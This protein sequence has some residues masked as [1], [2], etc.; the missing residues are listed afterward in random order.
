[1]KPRRSVLVQLAQIVLSFELL[2]ILLAGLT[3][4]GLDALQG[5]S[6]PSWVALV[7]TLGLTIAGIVAIGL[8]RRF[9]VLGLGL[10]WIIQI[11]LV[12][13]GFIVPAIWFV[14]ALFGGLWIYVIRAGSRIDSDAS[15]GTLRST[16]LEN[17]ERE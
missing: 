14:A 1:M 3:I 13:M 15:Q 11:S 16:T 17:G 5:L 7:A 9:P 2:I 10:G 12:V 8:L 6:L 4:L